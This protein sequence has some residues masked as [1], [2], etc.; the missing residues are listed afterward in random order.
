MPTQILIVDDD[1]HLARLLEMSFGKAGAA[2]EVRHDG[3]AA[4]D[5][6]GAKKFDAV[7]LDLLM[8]EKDGFHVLEERRGTVNTE[9]PVYIVTNLGQDDSLS[10]ALALGAVKCFVKSQTSP[11]DVVREVLEALQKK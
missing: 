3:K 10:R 5:A 2:V 7:L 9:T 1:V 8:P 4:L 11:Q 6:L